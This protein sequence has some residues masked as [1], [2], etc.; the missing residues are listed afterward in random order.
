MLIEE[1]KTICEI[2]NRP[3]I[4]ELSGTGGARRRIPSGFPLLSGIPI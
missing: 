3:D 4:K 1:L 2:V